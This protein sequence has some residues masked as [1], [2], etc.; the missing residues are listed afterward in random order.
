M[1]R[2]NEPWCDDVDGDVDGDGDV[3]VSLGEPVRGGGRSEIEEGFG[4][5][6]AMDEKDASGDIVEGASGACCA[7]ETMRSKAFEVGMG[8]VMSGDGKGY[9]NLGD[10][11]NGVPSRPELDGWMAS[12]ASGGRRGGGAR[13]TTCLRR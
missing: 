4:R 12:R 13:V 3:E 11:S 8:D 10:G 5:D 7:A 1:P 9:S 6:S 2:L